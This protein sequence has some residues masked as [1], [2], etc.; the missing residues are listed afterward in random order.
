[1]AG[2]LIIFSAPSGAGKTTIVQ[3]LVKLP[4]FNLEFS[5]SACCRPK[6]DGELGGKDYYFLSKDEFMDKIEQGEFLEWQEVYK[7]HYYGTLYS[8]VER[9]LNNN[10]NVIFDVDVEGG[11]NLKQKYADNALAVFVMPPSIQHL[12]QRLRDRSTESPESIARRMGKAEKELTVA[13]QFDVILYND[14]L[15]KALKDA[16]KIV[17]E[18]L[19][20]QE[21]SS[22]EKNRPF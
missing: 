17:E 10:K 11:L 4:K 1:M 22:T 20:K 16:E 5:I 18:Y 21:K 19:Q 2:K 14:N 6:R 3:H 9:I 7:D 12:E 13:D 8:E 15:E